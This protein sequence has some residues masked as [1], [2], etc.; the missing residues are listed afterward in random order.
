MLKEA[1]QY[2]YTIGADNAQ[3]EIIEVDGVKYTTKDMNAV[4]APTFKARPLT[5]CTLTAL[6]DYLHGKQ[7]E[8]KE[9]MIIHVK[10]PTE[11]SLFSGLD[12]HREREEL[13]Q[14]KATLKGFYFNEWYDQENFIINAQTNF[15]TTEDMKAIL[16]VAGNIKNETVANYGDDGT[17]QKATIS[18]GIA[19]EANVLIPNPVLIKPYRTFLE[20]KQ[21]ESRCVF[22]I[23]EDGSGKPKFKLIEADGG[24]WRMEAVANICEYINNNIPS[25]LKGR[26]TVIG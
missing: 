15:E 11:V 1:I 18:K 8:L 23:S 24:M 9:S 4:F 6:I 20:V 14:T 26:I 5:A 16:A 2:L 13:F 19:S 10:S 7:E 17:S 12:G 25:N 3:T 21:P 22:R